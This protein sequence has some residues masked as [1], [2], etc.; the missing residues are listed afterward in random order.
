MKFYSLT[1]ARVLEGTINSVV[2]K[3]SLSKINKS[4]IISQAKKETWGDFVTS[5]FGKPFNIIKELDLKD[6][7]KEIYS[8]V[9][10]YCTAHNHDLNL[11]LEDSWINVTDKYGFQNTHFHGYR[12]ISG[13]LYLD[14]YS[15]LQGVIGFSPPSEYREWLPKELKIIP[16]TGK[17]LVFYGGLLHQVSYNKTEIPRMSLSFNYRF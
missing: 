16:E 3:D 17:I 2:I 9:R 8:M 6:L 1:P 5:S 7:E 14:A 13:T 15:E 10:Y 11:D 4:G 12:Y